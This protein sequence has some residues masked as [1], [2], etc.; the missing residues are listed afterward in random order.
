MVINYIV[1]F[2]S[3][4]FIRSQLTIQELEE[5]NAQEI[6]NRSYVEEQNE[7]QR[8]ILSKY[9]KRVRPILNISEPLDVAVHVYIMHI[10]VNQLEQTITLNG[11][12]YMTWKDEYA[13]WEPSEH[14]GVRIT[15][16][17]QWEIW[18]PELKITNSVSGVG[19]FFEISK[20]SHVIIHSNGKAWSRIEIYPTFSIKIGCK[21][22]YSAYPYDTQKCALGIYTTNRMSEVQLSVYYNMQPTVLLGWGN[23][24]NKRHVSDWMIDSVVMNVS[25]FSGGKY[26]SE[27]PTDAEELDVSWSILYAWLT[28]HRNASS[29]ILTLLVPILVS[30][31]FVICSFLLPAPD[32]AIYILLANLFFL[33]IFLEDFAVMIPP[34]I[35]QLPKIVWFIGINLILTMMAIFLHLWLR[36]LLKRE[37][38]VAKWYLYVLH[39]KKIIPKRSRAALLDDTTTDKQN[40]SWTTI[41]N[42]IRMLLLIVYFCIFIIALI[43]VLI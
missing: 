5:D 10:S 40:T 4:S 11:H 23:Q 32:S 39:A 17:K 24:S 18:T 2:A 6:A 20:R 26:K 15:M 16:V 42:Y 35:G 1:L 22:D 9:N 43:I 41:V 19:Q 8:T 34:A 31:I 3:I 38:T 29:F 21:F 28:L 33:G 25:Y 36:Y 27:K 30:F 13:V 7:L 37:D 12:I 14:N